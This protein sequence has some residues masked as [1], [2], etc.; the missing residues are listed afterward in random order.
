MADSPHD[1]REF[2]REFLRRY[3]VASADIVV[4]RLE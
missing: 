3:V 1:R 2:F 4:D